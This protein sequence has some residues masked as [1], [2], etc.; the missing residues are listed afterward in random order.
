M[1]D[2][3]DEK[4]IEETFLVGP[5]FK[6]AKHP[7]PSLET[8][9]EHWRPGAQA[10]GYREAATTL[11]DVVIEG[12]RYAS[13][14]LLH[15]ILFLYRH[16]IELRMKQIIDSNQAGLQVTTGHALDKL[17]VECKNVIA[18]YLPHTAFDQLDEL[19]AELHAVD[20]DGQT[21][22]YATRK[23]QHIQI[24][25]DEI[26]LLHLRQK[27]SELDIAFEGLVT[28][29]DEALTALAEMNR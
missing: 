9:N 7:R 13:R 3:D 25:F 4:D 21:F 29:I 20:P 26:D 11:L 17:W 24:P 12:G 16:S 8:Y 10:I 5:L 23:G 15:P 18:R 19:I 27:M 14:T 28:E 2:A 1:S 6:Q 22:R